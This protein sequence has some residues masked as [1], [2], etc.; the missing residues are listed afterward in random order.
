VS[1]PVRVLLLWPGSEGAA[2]GNFGVPQLVLLG[3]VLRAQGRAH[4]EI[5]DL[6]IERR[7]GTALPE[8]LDGDDRCGYDVIALSVYSSFDH[9]LCDAIARMARERWPRAVIV[10]GGYHPSARPL[11][12][13]ADGSPFD[14]VVVGEGERPLCRIVE[15]VAGGAPLRQVV[16]GP[17]AIDHLD[18]LP[19]SDW[20]LLQRYRGVA[21]RYASQ[22]QVY[23]SRG[24]PFDCA[25][26][27]ERAKRE[28]SWRPLSVERALAEIEG[29]HR[30]LDLRSWTLYFGDALFG[31]KRRWR[32]EFLEALARRGIPVEKFWLLIRVDLVEDEDLRLFGA[33][34][35]GLGF[36]LES[37][38]PE[39]LATIR[40]S[41]R[42]DDYLERMEHIAERALEH[43]VP[44]GAN[45]ICGHPGET[46]ATLT[47]SAAYLRRLFLRPG[48]TTGF[49]SVDPF[50]LYP[51]SPIDADRGYYE[52]RFGTRFH[53]PHWW[54]DGD[55]EFLSEWV[56]PSA[57]LDWRG[58]EALQHELLAPLLAQIEGKFAYRGP[59][60]E[61]FMGA[62]RD[63]V[64]YTRP[65]SR[66][67]AI[68]RWYAWHGYLG[69][70]A[71]AQRARRDHPALAE[72][73]RH[74]R[75]QRREAIAELAGLPLEHAILAAIEAVPR[76]RFVPVEA[77]DDSTKDVAV[78]LDD[79]GL[80]SVSAMHAYA[81][82]YGW[83][84]VGP[85]D[86]V[87]D[88]GAGTGYGAAL[89]RAL[90]GEAGEVVAVEIDPAL[91]E[92]AQEELEPL[93]VRCALGDALDPATW[94]PGA[95]QL[96]KVTVGF[97]LDELPA[98]WRQALAPGT[99]IVAPLRHDGVL[100]LCRTVLCED[101]AFEQEWGH[102]VS[103][104]PA[105]T[106]PPTSRPIATAEAGMPR[107]R[108]APVHLTVL[109]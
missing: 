72:L 29:L 48:G 92:V 102:A 54:D 53:H 35:C 95:T 88:L 33:A 105:R 50:R 101:G 63:Q 27:M 40:K 44:W 74:R 4:V 82:A 64:A 78:A 109:D 80:A 107:S 38:D 14:V 75:A 22:A 18:E 13:I 104:V 21:R 77:I 10:A 71:A 62:I 37:G 76:E 58:R 32:R 42:L 17:E 86:G 49:L 60:R 61:Y 9:L 11:P 73:S 100:R 34:N 52:Q 30:F 97:A 70:R 55:P 83:L 12:Y 84:E 99:V 43:Q 31:M 28:V 19:P 45:V 68:E 23:L 85:G 15:S 91:L 108:S 96:R 8:I 90:V 67:P 47:R 16:L 7:L 39:L 57:E 59:A 41:G 1:A 6:A 51:G 79:S 5:R 2:A 26:C 20:S 98:A 46:P 69:R 103:Y 56:D 36:G 106:A 94:P 3:T 24:C 87:L 25:F 93:G 65:A 66:W 81:V 89:L